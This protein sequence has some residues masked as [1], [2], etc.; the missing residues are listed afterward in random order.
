MGDEFEK[1]PKIS[2]ES[3]I[4][5]G[6]IQSIDILE[7]EIGSTMIEL[8]DGSNLSV[9]VHIGEKTIKKLQKDINRIATISKKGHIAL[10]SAEETL[11]NL[12]FYTSEYTFLE[13]FLSLQEKK[14][15][16]EEKEKVK[17]ILRNYLQ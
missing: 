12:R 8:K 6:I 9:E 4:K 2:I 14:I 15:L 16:N 11:H 3:L 10:I 17:K 1:Y 5:E 13:Q 7:N